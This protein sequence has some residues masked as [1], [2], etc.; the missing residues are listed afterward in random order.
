MDW[1]GTL[2]IKNYNIKFGMNNLADAKYF[3]FRTVEYPGPGIIPSVG[4]TIYVGF[5]ARF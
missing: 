4:R 3:T 2:K 1:S 5:G